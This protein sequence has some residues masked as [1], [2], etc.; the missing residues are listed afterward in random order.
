MFSLE[1]TVRSINDPEVLQ[2]EAAVKVPSSM[3]QENGV[4]VQPTL[5]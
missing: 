1:V 5:R 4:C 3:V 2:I